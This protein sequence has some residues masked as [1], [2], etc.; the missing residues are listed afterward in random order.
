M[1]AAQ[2]PYC[3]ETIEAED[4]KKLQE[5]F[6]SCKS[7]SSRSKYGNIRAEYNGM[8]FDSKVER[9]YCVYLDIIKEAGE[10]EYYLRQ[11][12]FDLPGR[13]VYR[14]DYS[15]FYA[16]GHVEYVDVKGRLT[17]TF[18]LKKRQVEELYPVEIKIVKRKDFSV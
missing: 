5:H 3:G 18:K 10:V 9:D 16:D 11:T 8:A 7:S 2:C 13:T 17:D 4:I 14:C 15:V 12:R 1:I 6:D